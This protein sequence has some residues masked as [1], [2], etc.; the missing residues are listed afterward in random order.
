L[1]I[2]EGQEELKKVTRIFSGDAEKG[3]RNTVCKE[4]KAFLAE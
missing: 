1:Y 2:E 3:P 4:C